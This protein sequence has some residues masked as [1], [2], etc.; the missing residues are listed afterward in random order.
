MHNVFHVSLLKPFVEDMS[1]VNTELPALFSWGK[2]AARPVR[3][4]DRR[5]LWQNGNA[6]E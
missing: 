5:T 3:I 4:L 2:P 1:W 6:V